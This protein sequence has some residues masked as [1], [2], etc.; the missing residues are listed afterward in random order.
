MLDYVHDWTDVDLATKAFD[1]SR[2]WLFTLNGSHSNYKAQIQSVFSSAPNITL[3]T[4]IFV[5]F[6]DETPKLAEVYR[7][8]ASAD[9]SVAV[10]CEWENSASFLMN[11]ADKSIW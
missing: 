4:K 1:S 5:L 9:L 11:A 10:I 8:S 6:T 7:K 3:R 2:L